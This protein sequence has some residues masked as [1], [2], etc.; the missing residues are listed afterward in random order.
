MKASLRSPFMLPA[1]AV[2]D[3]ELTLDLPAALTASTGLDALTQLIEPYVSIR[4]N[5]MTDLYCVEGLRLAASALRR[6]WRDGVISPRAA[7]WLS[8]A[9]WA[10][11]R[12]PTPAW[13]RCTD[14]RRRWAGCS[15]RRTARFARRCC[16]MPWRRTSRRSA[17]RRARRG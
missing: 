5:A 16:R 2:V 13:A 17:A 14:S 8:P 9:C 12:W 1:L 7:T 6:A 11:W 3:P 4:A 10:A 15:M